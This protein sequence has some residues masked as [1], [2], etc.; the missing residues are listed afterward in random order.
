MRYQVHATGTEKRPY[1]VHD[2]QGGYGKP[3]WVVFSS[4]SQTAAQK[5]ADDMNKEA[6]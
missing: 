1:E 6:R 4:K 5:R 2:M 3:G